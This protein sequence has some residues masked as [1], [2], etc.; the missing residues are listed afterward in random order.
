MR[1]V[2]AFLS[3]SITRQPPGNTWSGTSD[4]GAVG[5]FVVV[6]VVVEGSVNKRTG[7][8]CSLNELDGW[9]RDT[10]LPLLR[11]RVT[12]GSHGLQQVGVVLAQVLARGR[13]AWAPALVLR[14]LQVS[15]SPYTRVTAVGGDTIL[16]QVT[17]SFDFSASHRLYCTD[18]S[19]EENQRAFG[20]CANRNGH[21]HNYVLDVTVSGEPDPIT[22]LLTDLPHFDRVVKE[23][24]IDR[25]DHKH[26]NLDCAEFAT[27]NPSVENIAR[28]IWDRLS[29]AFETCSLQSVRVWETPKTYAE[30][31]GDD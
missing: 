21:G 25:F 28:I 18:L 31:L 1:E 7:F 27:L 14:S 12:T 15:V 24:V 19:E 8:L 30:Y 2:R 16:V 9:M 20:K 3:D 11:D 17:Q 26:L 29:G 22:G 6:R 23:R 10:L 4:G 13:P 5:P